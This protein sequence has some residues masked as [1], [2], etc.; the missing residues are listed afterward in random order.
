MPISE[1]SEDEMSENNM[2]VDEIYKIKMPVDKM[3]IDETS[4]DK[5]PNDCRRND[6][7]VQSTQVELFTMPHNAGRHHPKD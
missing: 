6:N 1:V 5:M 4:K 3:T 2:F 7:A